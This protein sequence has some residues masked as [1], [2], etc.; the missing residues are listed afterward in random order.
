MA[1]TYFCVKFPI[2]RLDEFSDRQIVPVRSRVN[3]IEQL[4]E[5]LLVLEE[6]AKIELAT[7]RKM[8]IPSNRRSPE[9]ETAKVVFQIAQFGWSM[10]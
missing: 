4:F 2:E 10:K 9:G 3:G 1:L 6:P 7:I 5:P 8:S